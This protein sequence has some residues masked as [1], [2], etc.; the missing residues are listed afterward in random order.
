MNRQFLRAYK[1]WDYFLAR[2][3]YK[4]RLARF[5]GVNLL[6]IK[7]YYRELRESGFIETMAE[8]SNIYRIPLMDLSSVSFF[9]AP[10]LYVICRIIRPEKVVE[11]GV[12]RGMSTAFI[13]YALERN[14]RGRLYSIDWPNQTGEKL[15]EGKVTGWAIPD[16]LKQRWL[17][18]LGASAE[19]LPPLLADLGKID[20]F[21]HDSDHSY[22]NMM[23][24]FGAAI[25]HISAGGIIAADDIIDSGAFRDFCRQQQLKNTHLFKVGLARVKKNG[26]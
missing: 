4:Q 13:L 1:L 9:R 20:L 19:K 3:C 26:A 15:D 21:F 6:E 23:F 14:S 22:E 10:M 25:A 17:L 11:T 16:G 2:L 5:L 18:A 24:E 12:E 8:N 7:K